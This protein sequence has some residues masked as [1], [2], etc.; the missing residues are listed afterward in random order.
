MRRKVSKRLNDNTII[1]IE[2]YCNRLG[3]KYHRVLLFFEDTNDYVEF[4]AFKTNIG[5]FNDTTN[6]SY[7]FN[8]NYVIGYK[9]DHESQALKPSRIYDINAR[10]DMLTDHNCYTC[11]DVEENINQNKCKKLSLNNKS[12]KVK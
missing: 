9:Y 11:I 4:G 2:K 7:L 3:D 12:K 8:N 10:C 1:Q 6:D 5:I